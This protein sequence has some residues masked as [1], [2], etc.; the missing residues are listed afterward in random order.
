MRTTYTWLSQHAL[1]PSSNFVGRWWQS[2]EKNYLRAPKEQ[3][4]AK[5]LVQNAARGF[6][7]M[8]GAPIACIGVGRNAHLHGKDCT[9]DIPESAV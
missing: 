6:P 4:T 8:L 1:K 5:I 2:S 7:R 3:D 9:K